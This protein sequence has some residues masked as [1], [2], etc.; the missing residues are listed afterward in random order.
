MLYSI[1]SSRACWTVSYQG[2]LLEEHL[3]SVSLLNEA[4]S[5]FGVNGRSRLCYGIASGTVVNLL[6]DLQHV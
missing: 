2:T 4:L 6:H 1:N 3:T 5:N